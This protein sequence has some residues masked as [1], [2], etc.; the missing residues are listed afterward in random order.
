VY[1]IYCSTST[2]KDVAEL[3]GTK[4]AGGKVE[5]FQLFKKNAPET[6]IF[7]AYL[8]EKVKILITFLYI[9]SWVF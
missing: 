3:F 8:S 2:V 5:Q 9:S 4:V 6:I 7:S 1:G